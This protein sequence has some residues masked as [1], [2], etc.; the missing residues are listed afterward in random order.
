MSK[1]RRMS[2]N[3]EDL[4]H[5]STA[6]EV[7]SMLH[8]VPLD[9][10]LWPRRLCQAGR[11]PPAG[12]FVVHLDRLGRRSRPELGRVV[13]LALLLSGPGLLLFS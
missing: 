4:H 12:L 13:Q 6:D 8:G 9:P 3:V 11:P 10:L 5:G 1:K 2:G 7:D